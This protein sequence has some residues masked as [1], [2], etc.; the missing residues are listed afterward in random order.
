MNALLSIFPVIYL[1]STARYY[2]FF[3]NLAFLFGFL[4]LFW[5]GKYMKFNMLAWLIMIAGTY[6]GLIIGSKLGA[7][8]M[9]EWKLIFS[10]Y[11]IP[12]MQQK[13]AVGGLIFGLLFLWFFRKF[14]RF[15]YTYLHLFAY[16]FP[17]FIVVQRVG[18]LLA[19]C[20]YGNPTDHFWGIA[21]QLSP[22]DTNVE[23]TQIHP[24][25]IYLIIGALITIGVLIYFYKKCKTKR[26]F[27]I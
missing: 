7:F 18:C 12:T 21:Y 15:N 11:S 20:C 9:D 6:T 13:S 24:I 8:G 23:L 22:T 4:L 1:E 27:Y 14:I 17:V 2:D 25:P 5:L 3:Y 19:G 16:F 10:Q 26:H